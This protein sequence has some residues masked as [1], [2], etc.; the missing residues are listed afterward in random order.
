MAALQ[1]STLDA[2][3]NNQAQLL[4]EWIKGLEAN[5]AARNLKEQDLKQQTAEFLHLVV[6]GLE[7]GNGLSVAA[8]GWDE[9]R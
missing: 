6:N 3:K 4:A 5:G 7:K 9:A 8:P 1:I 2:M